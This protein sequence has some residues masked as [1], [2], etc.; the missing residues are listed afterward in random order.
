MTILRSDDPG[1]SVTATLH[2]STYALVARQGADSGRVAVLVDGRRVATVDL[3]ASETT[4][5]EVV[6]SKAYDSTDVREVTVRVL[7]RAD[8]RVGA[9]LD[10]FLAI[11]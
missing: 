9:Q 7:P 5:R 6:W 11:R 1:A 4:D 8:G 3:Y 10:A 2:G